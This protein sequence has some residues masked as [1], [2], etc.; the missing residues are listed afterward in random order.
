LGKRPESNCKV[1]G[2]PADKNECEDRAA[3][4]ARLTASA[5]AFVM[6]TFRLHRVINAVFLAATV[7]FAASAPRA[8]E[9]DESILKRVV[10]AVSPRRDGGPAARLHRRIDERPAHR[11]DYQDGLVVHAGGAY[12]GQIDSLEGHGGHA[13]AACRGGHCDDHCVVRPDR[14]GFYETQWRQWPGASVVQAA[15][16]EQLTPASPPRL[17]LPSEKEE[18]LDP[19]AAVEFGVD[20]PLEGPDA[21][22]LPGLG[23][24]VP[25]PQQRPPAAKPLDAREPRTVP[26]ENVERPSDKPAQPPLKPATTERTEQ[27]EQQEAEPESKPEPKKPSAPATP[28]ADDNLFDEA[29]HRRRLQ[30]R[31]AVI[32]SETRASRVAPVPFPETEPARPIAE[33]PSAES[34][35]AL[36]EPDSEQAEDPAPTGGV[37]P[38]I[39]DHDAGSVEA[40]PLRTSRDRGWRARLVD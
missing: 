21:T 31:L 27:P 23:P 22:T 28:S 37:R 12:A 33:R 5:E 2:D 25:P 8:V 4:A 6:D 26:D 7:V 39:Y 1:G 32:R 14:F 40:N 19:K 36:S 30:E 18:S 13:G 3:H 16:V 11:N 9:A 10:G 35:S 20:E 34:P 38:V 29:A 17:Q 15:G 24:I